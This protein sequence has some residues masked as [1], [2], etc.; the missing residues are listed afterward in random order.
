MAALDVSIP[1]VFPKIFVCLWYDPSV[2][3]AV[4][5]PEASVNKYYLPVPDQNN[6]RAA[7]E[8]SDMQSVTITK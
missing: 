7:G 3:T 5:V 8:F 4:H 6:I 2:F 1:F